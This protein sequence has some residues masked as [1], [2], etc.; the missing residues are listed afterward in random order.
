MEKLVYVFIMENLNV[1]ESRGNSKLNL[2]VPLQASKV[3]NLWP[4]LF[5]L[6]PTYL[7]PQTPIYFEANLR[8]Y[9]NSS[10][11]IPKCTPKR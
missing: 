8:Y 3:V 2:E 1:Y 7:P 6:Y 4:I 11:N 9:I 10:M 5:Y